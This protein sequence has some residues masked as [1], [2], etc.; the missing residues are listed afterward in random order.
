MG[1]LM[2][3]MIFFAVL[4]DSIAPAASYFMMAVLAL[5]VLIAAN[6]KLARIVDLMQK[7]NDNATNPKKGA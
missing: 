5:R 1:L 7:Q 2:V 4:H 3:L 6:D